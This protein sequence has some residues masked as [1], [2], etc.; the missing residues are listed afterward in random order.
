MSAS[1]TFH[2]LAALAY[3]LIGLSLWRPLTRGGQHA[4]LS[5]PS[6]IA[7]LGAIVLHGAGLLLTI[8]LPNG[9]HLGWALALSAAIW[10]GLVIFWFDSL[11]L[12]LDSLLLILLP[13]ATIVCLLAA[14]FPNGTIV[15]HGD[16]R[17]LRA[18]LLI[19]LIAYGLIT[20]AALHAVFMSALERQ[21]HQP[22]RQA[23]K[24]SL[25]HRALD[26]MPPLLVQE[27]LLFRLIRFGFVVLTLT[28]ATGMVVSLRADGTLLPMD[29]KTLFTLLSWLTFGA[30]LGGRHIWGWRGHKALRWTL[31]GFALLIL[32]Y[33]GTRF[34]LDVLLHRG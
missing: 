10:L 33:S 9:L 15:H 5:G 29:H 18:H 3:G 4:V 17:W 6:R 11:F 27:A 21:L 32:S 19:A 7:L 8:V 28:V 23:L 13:A 30:L 25:F 1:I 16:S 20:V 34:V 26:T 12:R 14:L 2:L 24:P 22:S 31:V